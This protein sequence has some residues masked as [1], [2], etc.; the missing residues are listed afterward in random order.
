[1]VSTQGNPGTATPT[2]SRASVRRGLSRKAT[3]TAS[4]ASVRRGLSPTP[5][6]SRAGLRRGVT[7]SPSRLRAGR[8]LPVKTPFFETQRGELV[9]LLLTLILLVLV[10]TMTT[11]YY[12]EVGKF[13]D[14]KEALAVL[15]AFAI[16]QDTRFEKKNDLEVIDLALNLTSEFLESVEE[17]DRLQAEIDKLLGMLGEW[18]IYN[19]NL[20]YFSEDEFT[21]EESIQ[22]C[23]KRESELISV[24]FGEE[25]AFADKE[26]TRLNN[27]YWIGLRKNQSLKF[28]VEWLNLQLISTTYWDVKKPKGDGD[29]IYIGPNCTTK[30]C[31]RDNPCTNKKRYLCKKEPNPHWYII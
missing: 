10:V 15:R 20:Y 8:R 27:S 22:E 25:Q 1:M 11:L 26:A 29:C 19:R 2:A 23:I 17:N 7:P 28:G 18:V 14:I 5:A 13:N 16:K 12:Q 4:R 30:H 9:L 3:P 24:K 31:W 6:V 21:W